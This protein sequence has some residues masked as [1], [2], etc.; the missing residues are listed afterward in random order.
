MIKTLRYRPG[1][2]LGPIL[3]R[4]DNAAD[5]RETVTEIIA[6]VRERGD[7][8]LYE[9]AEKFDQARLDSLEVSPREM[10]EALAAT[11]SGFMGVLERAAENI[12]RF[13]EQ[14]KRTGFILNDRPGVVMGQKVTPVDRAGIY[15]PGGK[16]PLSS[17]VLMDAIPA[18]I[19]GVPEVVMV[20]APNREGKIQSAILAAAHV[21]GVKRIFKIGGAQAIAALAYGTESVPRVDKIVGPGGALV[22]EAKRQV[23]GQVSIDMIAGP[24]EVLIISDSG[25]DPRHLAADM[26]AQAEHDTMATAILITDSETLAAAA[27]EELERQ[28]PK[29]EREEIARTSIEN[30]GRII[31][32]PDLDTAMA[33]ADAVAPEHLELSLDEPFRW[34]DRVCH[35]GSVFL[36]RHCPEALG[37]YMAGANHT[38]P[39]GGTARFS[40]P[41]GVD[42]FIKK[43]QYIYYSPEALSRVARDV[44]AFARMEGLTAHARSAMIRMEE[45]K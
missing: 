36:G 28:L 15:V 43:T 24:S 2:D 14:Q 11:D 39:T 4:R 31:L 37:D 29:L 8:A 30:N 25:S 9:Y 10:E 6:C 33:I 22:A 18:V 16:A 1:E 12:R 38:L 35:A 41:L 17:T 45:D 21:A 20:T 27:A 7:A 23:Y 44:D 42:D 13:H 3:E 32:V 5:V 34:L 26:L 19:A 40:S